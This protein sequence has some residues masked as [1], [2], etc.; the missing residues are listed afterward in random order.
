MTNQSPRA[1]LSLYDRFVRE[2]E[3]KK[4]R[5]I[6]RRIRE[7][8]RKRREKGREGK[9]K[10]KTR[11]KK[12]REK[13][14]RKKG[15]ERK[16]KGIS[17]GRLINNIFSSGPGVAI[18]PPRN[19]VANWRPLDASLFSSPVKHPPLPYHEYPLPPSL[20][21]LLP[22]LPS[23]HSYMIHSYMIYVYTP[24][25]RI[26]AFSL[27]TSRITTTSNHLKHP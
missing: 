27:Y 19:T 23:F 12:E 22:L 20:L 26:S 15:K 2:K 16:K 8:K 5:K 13:K 18:G 21:P 3:K 10:E 1:T 14:R 6:R 9:R 11:E 17:S 7:K 25:Q 4:K 24:G